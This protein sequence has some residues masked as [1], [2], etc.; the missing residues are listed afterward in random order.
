M[1]V[2]SSIIYNRPK[3]ETTPSANEG[4]NKKWANH[5]L[6]YYSSIKRNEVVM[7]ATTWM[8]LENIMLDERNQSPMTT[9]VSLYG[10][11]RIN[12]S[13]EKESRLVLARGWR[14]GKGKGRGRIVG[15]CGLLSGGM[16]MFWS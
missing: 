12:K 10:V 16:K 11:S 4:I 13:I 6:E 9:C 7:H 2:H 3:M 8:N 1:N 14:K 5:T 15:R